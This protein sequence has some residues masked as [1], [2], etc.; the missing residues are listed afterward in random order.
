MT[1]QKRYTLKDINSF[2]GTTLIG[3][4]NCE[5]FGLG[6]LDRASPGQLS[7]LSNQS[8]VDQ[9]AVS[10]ASAIILEERF[11]ERCKTN[12]IIS[13]QPYV[14]F[15]LASSL[16]AQSLSASEGIHP[17]AVIA[18]GVEI[19]DGVSIGAHAIIE[20]NVVVGAGS[21]IGPN[22]FLGVG[23]QMG[24][25]CRLYS[26]VTFYHGVSTGSN[27]IVHSGAVIG[28]DGF[29]FAFDGEKSVKIHQL[30][31]VCIGD[32][33]EIGAGTTIDRGA[34][35]DTV[36]EHGVKIDNQVQIGHNTR[37]GEH[38]VICGCTAIAGSTKIGKYCVL[39]GASGII[40]HLSIAD[41]VQVS[42]MSLISQSI[43]ES[44]T[45]SSGT[46]QMKT[47]DW[48]RA[49]IRFQQLDKLAQRLKELEKLN[50]K[51]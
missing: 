11:T 10:K 31:G 50:D 21:V 38:T 8:Y 44:G 33:V 25:N 30:G 16:F 22:C 46:A 4:E 24:E 34:I 1:H 6:T 47:S 12:A 13:T 43:T 29:G 17:T 41:G 45:Y 7:F 23:V 20:K 48:K 51:Q 3:D 28:A 37:V 35:E 15:A 5:I 19:P 9:L 40:G 14:S 26:N 32:D 27:V 49:A 2:L 42:A 18:A 39:G 36:I